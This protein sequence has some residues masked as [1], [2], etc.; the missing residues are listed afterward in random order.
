ML[1][2][3]L[4]PSAVVSVYFVFEIFPTG[5]LPLDVML[6]IAKRGSF[7]KIVRCFFVVL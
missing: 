1:V 5:P 3:V 6:K 4:V 7:L 2:V